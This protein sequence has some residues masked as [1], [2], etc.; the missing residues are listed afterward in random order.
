MGDVNN[1][2]PTSAHSI[3]EAFTGDAGL[4]SSQGS[5]K[6]VYPPSRF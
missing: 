1:I 2:C 6:T 4:P 5:I 3:S